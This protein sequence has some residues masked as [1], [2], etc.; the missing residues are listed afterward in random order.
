[1]PEPSTDSPWRF[2]LRYFAI[3]AILFSIYAFPYDSFGIGETWFEAYLSGYARLAGAALSLVE[4]AISVHGT[5][6]T[7]RTSLQIVKSCDAM[8]AK[9][10]FASA[11][12][13]FHAPLLPKLLA[14]LGGLLALTALNVLRIGSLYYIILMSR[15][16]FE[17]AHLEVWPLVM[18][19]AT[20]ALFFG[21]AKLMQARPQGGAGPL[22]HAAS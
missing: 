5:F 19:V 8:D 13:A 14:M 22:G 16:A 21:S 4:P 15:D 9:L 1:M 11:I 7:G 20:C 17:I 18:V 12:L 10:L 3:A 2:A 6:I